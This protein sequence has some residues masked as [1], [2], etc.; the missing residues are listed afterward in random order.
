MDQL[1]PDNAGHGGYRR[2]L[3]LPVPRRLALA[4]I[5][6]DFA[7]WLDYAAIIA[8]LVFAWGEGPFV[9][10]LF[11]LALTLPYIVVGPLLAVVVDRTPLRRILVLSN[12]GRGLTTL[13]LIFAPNTALVLLIVFARACIDSAFTPAR[14]AAIQASTPPELLGSANGLHQAINQ[15]SK[16]AGPALGGLLLAFIP[17]QAV[18]GIN[19][20]LSLLGA[21]ICL[22]MILPPKPKTS[23]H[24]GLLAEAAAGI[25][26]FRRSRRLLA[27][28]IFSA[29]A[30]FSFFLYDALIALLAQEFGLDATAFGI[31]IAAS[32]GGGLLGAFWAGKLAGSHPMQTMIAAAAFSGSVTVFIATGALIGIAVPA[33]PFYLVL[34]LMGGATAFML[35][36]YRTIVQSETPPDRI[37]R[38]FATGEAVITAVMLSAPFIGSF[39]AST[40]GTAMAFLCGGVMLVTLGLVGA[41]MR[42]ITPSLPPANLPK[43][44]ARDK[45][46]TR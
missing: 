19:A 15:T 17:A 8:L 33:L 9:L 22:G 28:L 20:L 10:A 30:Y 39:I 37:A 5:P 12:L 13:A 42:I 43:P 45:T 46:A 1:S 16:I 3:A 2:L 32:G 24:A 41:M 27:A 18:F 34:A 23:Q 40:W 35:V 21:M 31:S 25:S 38:V 44:P 26:E 6:A 14:Q 4:S 7:D 11:A 36:P 29:F